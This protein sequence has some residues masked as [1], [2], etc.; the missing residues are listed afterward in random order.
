MSTCLLPKRML[1]AHHAQ[2]SISQPETAYPSLLR[3]YFLVLL[4]AIRLHSPFELRDALPHTET[5]TQKRLTPFF[6][7][8]RARLGCG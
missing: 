4:R 1:R 8:V 2:L 7:R 5:K 6:P 3:K